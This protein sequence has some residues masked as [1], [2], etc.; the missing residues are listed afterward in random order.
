MGHPADRR[1]PGGKKR[2]RGVLLR[3][4]TPLIGALNAPHS[5]A[6][7]EPQV[8][9]SSKAAL[10]AVVAEDRRLEDQRSIETLQAA[11]IHIEVWTTKLLLKER[12]C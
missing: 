5:P 7:P 4:N 11:S 2:F 9:E 3:T 1:V 12:G 8:P 6:S 10:K